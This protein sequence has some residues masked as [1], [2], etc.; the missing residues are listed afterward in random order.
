MTKK[1][2]SILMAVLVI[3]ALFAGCKNND[4]KK[5]TNPGPESHETDPIITHEAGEQTNVPNYTDFPVPSDTPYGDNDN[6]YTDYNRNLKNEVPEIVAGQSF[7]VQNWSLRYLVTFKEPLGSDLRPMYA[8]DSNI[9]G[10]YGIMDSSDRILIR[11]MDDYNFAFIYTVSG[12]EAYDVRISQSVNKIGE[13][14]LA[15][16]G[17]ATL[18][19][20]VTEA[21]GSAPMLLFAE[22]DKVAI[23]PYEDTSDDY[24]DGLYHGDVLIVRIR[25]YGDNA[26]AVRAFKELFTTSVL[27]TTDRE[28]FSTSYTLN[29]K[30][31]DTSAAITPKVMSNM[32]LEPFQLRLP[33]DADDIIIYYASLRFDLNKRS[34]ALLSLLQFLQQQQLHDLPL[35]NP[36]PQAK[37]GERFT[38]S[39]A[40]EHQSARAL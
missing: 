18:Y 20:K 2:I 11:E 31:V 10:F 38:A 28:D 9:D 12:S 21:D 22:T 16:V 1:L 30:Q 29:G 14:E 35:V 8:D 6:T 37:H 36:A 34:E 15:T 39:R 25:P 13:G 17:D 40:P 5:E 26:D 23:I 3:T 19:E 24:D 33:E 4:G 32:V 7:M 27:H